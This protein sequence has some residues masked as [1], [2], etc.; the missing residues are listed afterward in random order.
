MTAPEPTAAPVT[1]IG[2]GTTVVRNETLPPMK[3]ASGTT[4]VNPFRL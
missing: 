4:T 2:Q 3:V 1:V